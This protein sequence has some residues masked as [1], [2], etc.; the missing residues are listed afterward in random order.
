VCRIS[1]PGDRRDRKDGTMSKRLYVGNL[2]TD[3]TEEGL[4][5][6]FADWK[7]SS[8]TLPT[9]SHDRETTFGFIEIPDEDQA[10]LAIGAMNGKELNGRALTVNEARPRQPRVGGGR[11]ASRW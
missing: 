10:A 11:D 2:T 9:R 1:R 5:Q 6:A 8:V 3:I 7:P 4:M